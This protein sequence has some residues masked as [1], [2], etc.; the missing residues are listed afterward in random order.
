VRLGGEQALVEVLRVALQRDHVERGDARGQ[1]QQVV[2]AGEG[3]A[4]Q[5]GHHRGAV[6]Q[7]QGFLGPQHQ[8]G[9]A[10]F[11][12]HVGGLAAF[13]TEQH[14]RSPDRVAAT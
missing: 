12:V 14:S 9:P 7:R 4:G 5:A 10:Q 8:R 11:A 2:G 3:Q 1:L 13:A 6:H